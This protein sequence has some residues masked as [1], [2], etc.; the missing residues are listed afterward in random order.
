MVLDGIDVFV[1]VVQA[2]SF[3][4]AARQLGMP[5]TT[6]SLKIA[7]LESRLGTTLIQ[8]ST[9][10]MHVTPAGERYFAHCLAALCE[11][12]AGEEQLAAGADE[13]AGLLRIT[14]PA[15]LSQRL[16][17]M[18]VQRYLERYPRATVEL[19]VTNAP[20]DLLAQGID[21]AIRASPMQDSSLISRKFVSGMLALFATP[22]YLAEHGTPKRPKDLAR[23]Q[24]HVLA[25][26]PPFVLKLVSKNGTLQLEP[27]ARVKADDMETVRSFVTLGMG[28]GLLP[29]L[30]IRQEL[31][32]VLPAYATPPSSVFFVHAA[33]RFV[34]VN[35]R[36]FIDLA[37]AARKEVLE[38]Q[39]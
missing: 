27:T 17:P 12:T 39:Q 23:H 14:A 1:K 8:R 9:R 21:L 16:L 6:V 33:Q 3:S 22:A 13:P 4:A 34:P 20:L 31:Q 19:V 11:L 28:I 15:D 38:L 30:A 10:R 7:R 37:L 18:L 25:G 35:V 2:G 36:A 29:V 24:V 26:M 5:A 32:R